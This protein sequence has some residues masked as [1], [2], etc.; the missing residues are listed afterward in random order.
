MIWLKRMV[1]A[2]VVATISVN[3]FPLF[4]NQSLVDR[5]VSE[6]SST[7]DAAIQELRKLDLK[8][9]KKLVKPLLDVLSTNKF[10]K[11]I[12]AVYALGEIGPAA[13]VAV[14]KLIDVLKEYAGYNEGGQAE[15]A[16]DA[17][18]KIGN[19]SVPPLVPLLDD[20]NLEVRWLA[21]HTLKS[22]GSPDAKAA[23]KKKGIE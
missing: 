9:K 15:A 16:P 13:E 7:Q 14:P 4:A 23:L 8:S 18:I 19:A 3:L 22:I 6:D 17:L 11:H 10:R 20:Q 2:L 1:V 5:L 21:Q 12:P